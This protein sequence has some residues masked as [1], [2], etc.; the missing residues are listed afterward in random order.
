MSS[1]GDAAGARY[2]LTSDDDPDDFWGYVQDASGLFVPLDDDGRRRVELRGCDPRGALLTAADRIGTKRAQVGNADL[3]FL[4]ER[5]GRRLGSY[6]VNWLTVEDRRPSIRYGSDRYDLTVSLWC[7]ALPAQA[8]WPWRLIRTGTLDR[9][10]L[11]HDLDRDGRHAWMSVALYRR[12]NRPKDDRPPGTVY[13]L[14]GSHVTDEFS[15]YCAL[16]EAVNGPGGYFGWNL[17][18]IDD[19]LGGRWGARTPFILVW[20]DSAASVS[21]LQRVAPDGHTEWFDVLMKIF[22]DCEVDIRFR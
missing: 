16:G 15:F 22:E 19:C 20:K 8:E 10:G 13:E 12:S 1:S 17:S 9:V 6:F 11:W 7:N 2:A 18:A 4:D 3:D 21:A 5:S 14:D